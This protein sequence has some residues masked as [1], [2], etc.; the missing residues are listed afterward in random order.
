MLRL[1]LPQQFKPP[2]LFGTAAAAV[3]TEQANASSAIA[4]MDIETNAADVNGDINPKEL[5]IL[6]FIQVENALELQSLATSGGN[7][8]SNNSFNNNNDNNNSIDRRNEFELLPHCVMINPALIVDAFQLQVA[9][10][11]AY[12]NYAQNAMKT[13][14]LLTE[15]LF[16]LSP[17]NT[18][19]ESLKKFG[20]SESSQTIYVLFPSTTWDADEA[21][22]A[23]LQA[24]VRGKIKPIERFVD[25]ADLAL[26]KKVYKLGDFKDTSHKKLVDLIV[27]SIAAKNHL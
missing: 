22:V 21:V 4:G 20:I 16:S 15:I 14:T 10:A 13:R 17:S 11:R 19:T 7:S 3:S 26:V 8:N 25:G 24:V 12:L 9:C 1:S 18:I 23:R 6:Q 27:G 5:V 2:A